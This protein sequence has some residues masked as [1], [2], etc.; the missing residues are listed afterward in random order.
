MA[1]NAGLGALVAWLAVVAG[2]YF[3]PLLLYPLLVGVVTGAA[4]VGLV[5]MSQTGNRPTILAG[6]LVAALVAAAGQHYVKYRLVYRPAPKDAA[7][8]ERIRG[9][10]MVPDFATYIQRMAEQGRKVY[11]RRIGGPALAWTS[12]GLEAAL[13]TAAALALAA[14]A[15]RQPYCN[16]CHSWYHITRS[17]RLAGARARRLAAAAGVDLP[18]EVAVRY[19]LA[20]CNSGCGPSGL[21]LYWEQADGEPAAARSWLTAE[22]RRQVAEVLDAAVDDQSP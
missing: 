13:L 8:F 11:G 6:A 16:R 21:A 1:V 3:A 14:L 18:W 19:R 17:G 5:R 22:Q 7:L 9:L 10:P 12:W 4:T 15:A 2:E 20:N